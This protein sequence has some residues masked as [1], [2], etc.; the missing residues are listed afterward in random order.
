MPERTFRNVEIDLDDLADAVVEWFEADSFE[1]QDFQEGPSIYIQARRQNLLST[2]TG[3]GKALNVR[4]SPLSRGFKIEVGPGD[5][6]DKGI[7]AGVAIATR[8]VFLPLAIGTGI[9]TG[10]GIYKQLKLPDQLLD[11]VADYVAQ[12]GVN[13]E[14]RGIEERRTKREREA[15]TRVRD[16]DVEQ[17]LADLRRRRGEKATA[18]RPASVTSK[19][20]CPE[21]GAEVPSGSNFCGS[22]GGDLR[23]PAAE[24]DD[25]S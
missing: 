20:Y 25:E 4:L 10:W 14:S 3:T 18:S 22:C 12:N 17:E 9:A 16:D 2:V 13:L 15:A 23:E 21:C 8:F 19:R 11:F 24:P 1:V 7:G 6:L 5:W